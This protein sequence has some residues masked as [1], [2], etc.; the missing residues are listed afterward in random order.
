M[1]IRYPL[2]VPLLQRHQKKMRRSL[3]KQLTQEP[4]R[5]AVL[6]GSTTN[7]VCQFLEL[8]LLNEGINVETYESGYNQFYQEAVF[9]NSELD[10][11]NPQVIYIHTSSVNIADWPDLSADESAVEQLLK[12]SFDY[13]H[14]V[15]QALGSKYN[16]TI[17]QNN[18]E[19]PFSR[20]LGNLDGSA[21]CGKT[22][23][24]QKLNNLFSEYSQTHSGLIL[25]DINY[26]SAW[27]GLGRWYDK[28]QWYAYKYAMSSD[29]VP[30]LAYSVAA[31]VKASLGLSKKAVVCDLDNTL[32]GGIIGDDGLNGIK[33]G[34]ENADAEA[35]S[36][37]QHYLKALHQRGVLLAVCSKNEDENARLGFTHPDSVLG[38]KDFSAFEANWNNKD[39][40]IETIA[41]TLNIGLDSLA[42]LDDNPS[43]RNLVSNTHPAVAVPDIGDNITDYIRYLD[44]ACLFE[45]ISLNKEDIQ[46]ADMYA[47]NQQR[48]QLQSQHQNYGD[49]LLSLNMQATIKPFDDV[50]LERVAQL[51]NKTN[52]FNLTTYRYGFQ[53]MESFMQSSSHITLYGRLTDKFGDN[54]IVSV[55]V[56]E[57]K[58]DALHIQLW[59]MS[60]RVFKRDLEWAMFRELRNHA[61]KAGITSLIGHYIPT[62][63]NGLVKEHYQTL[64]FKNTSMEEDGSSWWEYDVTDTDLNRDIPMTIES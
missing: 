29:A 58:A 21:V 43:E 39:L 57:Q 61:R 16:A 28:A 27:F 26:L 2:D 33:I 19:L 7:E 37:L 17:I 20:P 35:F 41:K 50:S 53:E 46:R 23:F 56:G 10:A 42:F 40:N 49:Y 14:A 24:T 52:Q 64:G 15:W 13:Y 45:L 22:R 3:K 63:K 6:G 59:L 62:K 8:F 11:F 9:D 25:H 30:E 18:F 5:I 38:L 54:G 1:K 47:Q 51:T 60:C 34:Q 12:N 48:Q 32:W 31:Q 44:K 4:L 36:D 55:V